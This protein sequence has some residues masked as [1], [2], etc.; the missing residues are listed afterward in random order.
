[1]VSRPEIGY[2][3]RRLR[4]DF[5]T[6]RVFWI[7]SLRGDLVGKE[8]GFL[9]VG[10]RGER[11]WRVK[12]D[13]FMHHRS[14]LIF[15]LHSGRWPEDGMEVDHINGDS[16]DDR[17]SNLREVT[18]QQNAWNRNK[19]RSD[20]PMGVIERASGRFVAR[21]TRNRKTRHIGVFC[22]PDEAHAAYRAERVKLI[23]GAK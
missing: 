18:R 21:V 1:M 6:G 19:T 20:L 9:H 13:G 2:L 17:P 3:R 22:S 14:R 23:G 12:V 10:A 15:A 7:Q 11:Y 4:P 5:A 8:A 16:T